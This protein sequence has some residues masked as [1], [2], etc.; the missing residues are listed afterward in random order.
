[1]DGGSG[2]AETAIHELLATNSQHTIDFDLAQSR[3][4]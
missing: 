1:M 4:N 2:C 3:S